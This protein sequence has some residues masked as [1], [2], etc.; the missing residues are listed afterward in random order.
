MEMQVKLSNLKGIRKGC[1]QMLN[2]EGVSKFV[3]AII[4]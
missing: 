3:V 4:W 1:Q 2:G